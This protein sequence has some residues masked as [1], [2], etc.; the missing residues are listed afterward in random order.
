MTT[1]D[2]ETLLNNQKDGL[3]EMA[4]QARAGNEEGFA[5]AAAGVL[6]ATTTQVPFLGPLASEGMK[7]IWARSAYAKF[8]AHLAELEADEAEDARARKIAQ[9]TAALMAEA[10]VGFI[11][12]LREQLASRAQIEALEQKLDGFADAFRGDVVR[13]EVQL[14]SGGA[15][16]I[17]LKPDGPRRKVELKIDEATGPGTT[18]IES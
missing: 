17:R 3:A 7:A 18:V 11:A 13:A 5:V 1:K 12:E 9:F 6:V 10:L 14:L 15:T 8:Q 16:G 2:L 4:K